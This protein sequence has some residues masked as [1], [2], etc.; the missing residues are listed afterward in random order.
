MAPE[1]AASLS[2]TLSAVQI[3]GATVFQAQSFDDL[4]KPLV[5]QKISV[6]KIFDVA[7]AITQ[8]YAQDGY[9]LSFAVVPEQKIGQ[10]GRVLIHVVEGFVDKI[11]FTGDPLYSVAEKTSPEG[12]QGKLIEAMAG[13]IMASRPLRSQ[14]MERYVLLINSIP[15]VKATT[16]FTASAQL[17]AA[18]TL[19]IEVT[20]KRIEVEAFADNRQAKTLKRWEIGGSA[21]INGFLAES[22]RLK[23]DMIC[24]KE[25]CDDAYDFSAQW[26]TFI[27][28]DG[29]ALTVLY[30]V[31]RMRPV[32]GDMS[33]LAF[34]GLGRS[35][36]VS[37]DY[38]FV[39]TRQKKVYGGLGLKAVDSRTKTFAGPLTQ[40]KV[41]TA[42]LHA[43]YDVA[44]TWRGSTIL[45][46]Q[47]VKGIPFW[48]EASY[49][50]P[51]KSRAY[52]SS[53]FVNLTFYAARVQPLDILTPELADVSF[54]AALSGQTALS[55]ALLS[56][57]Q[58]SYGGSSFGRGYEG[59]VVSGDDCLQ[60]I[61]ELRY[62][63]QAYNI[64]FQAY[65]FGDAGRAWI[66]GSLLEDE[67][68]STRASS[69]G[70]GV[71]VLEENIFSGD[72]QLAFPLRST[73]AETN[74]AAPRLFF[75]VRARY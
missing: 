3:E 4:W 47:L 36:G 33:Q 74:S 66:K 53:S 39:L 15:G 73:Y 12:A 22:D 10:D 69:A 52:G 34:E 56:T 65:L 59:G 70:L 48:R 43:S 9:V 11:A 60:G 67:A 40:D 24:S 57:S 17:A 21:T 54:F 37:V 45:T 1:K 26:S 13:Q 75:S 30:G 63:W 49:D 71:R 31:N 32:E 64:P 2:L 61:V 7:A 19:T 5:G 35:Y 6:A 68:R 28:A 44:D 50:D 72:L 38:P 18:S 20:R 29:L 16:R 23:G 25:G 42:D 58:C 41:R 27:G 8:R 55:R 46:G 14:D 51:L 62:D